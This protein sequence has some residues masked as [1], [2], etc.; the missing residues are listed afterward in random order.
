MIET[1]MVKWRLDQPDLR[2]SVLSQIIQNEIGKPE[3]VADAVF[4][5]AS[6]Q[7][8]Y[9]NGAALPMDGGWKAH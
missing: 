4:Y 9:F 6:D 1:P 2:Q 3:Q 5:L 8:N 7:S